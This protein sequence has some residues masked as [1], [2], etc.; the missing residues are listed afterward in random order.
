MNR[1]PLVLYSRKDCC[2]CEALEK[3]LRGLSLSKFSPPLELNVIDIDDSDIPEH[4]RELYQYEV[5][6]LVLIEV[7]GEHRRNVTLPRVSPRLKGEGLARWLRQ[8]CFKALGK[9]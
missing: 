1:L 4:V 2:L 7:L 6:V 3:H 8:E 9:N 5:P